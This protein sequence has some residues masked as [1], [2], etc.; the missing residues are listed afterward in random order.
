MELT[1]YEQELKDNSEKIVADLAKLVNSMSFKPDYFI[2]AMSREHR[3]LQQSFTKLCLQWLEH[4]ASD[5][6]RYD[7][8]NED[9]HELCKDL[10][11]TYKKIGRGF[12]PSR[13]L[14]LI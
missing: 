12:A 7:G 9:S 13:M 14:P 10:I 4:V 3:T 1:K 5:K 2:G 6:Y 11:T 8:R